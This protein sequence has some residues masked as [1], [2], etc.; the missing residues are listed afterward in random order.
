VA[1]IDALEQECATLR[2]AISDEDFSLSVYLTGCAER[3]E[4]DGYPVMAR[5]IRRAVERIDAARAGRPAGEG[6]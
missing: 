1:H 4:E 5:A 3:E 2:E 6:V